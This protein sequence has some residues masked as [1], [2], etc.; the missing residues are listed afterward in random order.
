MV[1]V[2]K[3]RELEKAAT[4]GPWTADGDAQWCDEDG[5]YG[6]EWIDMPRQA[7]TYIQHSR[8]SGEARVHARDNAALIVEARNALPALLDEIEALRALADRAMPYVE[9][10]NFESRSD[11]SR[12]WLADYAKVRGE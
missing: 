6:D 10:H 8:M 12:K 7:R 4:P 1:D 9:A 5:Y 11:V 2:A 3:L